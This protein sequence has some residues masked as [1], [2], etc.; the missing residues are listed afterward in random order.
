MKNHLIAICSGT[1]G[2]GKT[3]LAVNLS[4]SLALLRKKVLFFD[5]DCGIENISYQLDFNLKNSYQ[6]L[7]Y[8]QLI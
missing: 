6:T 7:H 2:I 5:A 8:E 1:K 4:H 3:W